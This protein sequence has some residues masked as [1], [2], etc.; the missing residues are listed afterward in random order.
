MLF[1]SI[2]FVLVTHDQE[3]ALSMSDL[4]C[5]MKDGRIVQQG[6][7]TELYDEP[8]N[9]YVADF[10]GKSNFLPGVLLDSGSR[11][12][13]RLANGAVVSGRRPANAVG[14]LASQAAVDIAVRP[15]LIAMSRPGTG[16]SQQNGILIKATVKNRIFL[17]ENTEYL[18]ATEGLGDV[19]VLTPKRLEAASGSFAPGDEALI[20]WQPEAA[21]LLTED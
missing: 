8:T 7:P 16:L 18:V 11:P 17:G 15:E 10:V 5:V 19:L 20:S 3:E 21:L 9:R 2:T 6:T 1:R 13:A 12:S 4:V 14:A